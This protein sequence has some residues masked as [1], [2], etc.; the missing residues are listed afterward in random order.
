MMREIPITNKYE[1]KITPNERIF[2][3]S[4]SATIAVVA[5]IKG[6]GVVQNKVTLWGEIT[7]S[8]RTLVLLE[9]VDKEDMSNTKGITEN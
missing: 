4:P 7:N 3:R 6:N 5:R 2:S 9:L 1:R 8:N